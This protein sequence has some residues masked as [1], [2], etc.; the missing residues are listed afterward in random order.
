MIW[1]FMF[2]SLPKAPSEP[3]FLQLKGR[4]TS[5]LNW[6]TEI[7]LCVQALKSFREAGRGEWPKPRRL[8]QRR[9]SFASA[10]GGD[11]GGDVLMLEALGGGQGLRGA[12][13]PLPPVSL[14]LGSAAATKVFHKAQGLRLQFTG[15]R[16]G[17]FVNQIHRA[18]GCNLTLGCENG[19]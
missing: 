1:S 6:F 7:V 2:F 19:Q 15:K 16:F 4:Q 18:H 11:F 9:P 14:G 3:C 5:S 13:Q 17:F 12:R 10:V 8:C